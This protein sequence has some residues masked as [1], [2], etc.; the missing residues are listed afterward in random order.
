MKIVKKISR[1]PLF[2]FSVAVVV[3]TVVNLVFSFTRSY[4]KGEYHY[5]GSLE[6]Y[7]LEIEM[8]LGKKGCGKLEIIKASQTKE[9]DIKIVIM[10]G[11]YRVN[12]G[13]LLLGTELYGASELKVFG[14]VSSFKIIIDEQEFGKEIVL[15]N[16]GA[17]ASVICSIV[18]LVLG[19]AG[20]FTSLFFILISK[21]QK[22][23]NARLNDTNEFDMM[24]EKI[25]NTIN[26]N[27]EL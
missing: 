22:K 27:E 26:S 20:V 10:E 9:D 18:F 5:E 24:D 8:N 16:S 25:S 14:D 11:V 12:R 6:G 7:N 2:I 3:I 15:I 19:V 4:S 1:W 21:F 13:K 17:K 23:S